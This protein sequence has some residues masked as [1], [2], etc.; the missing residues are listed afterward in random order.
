[1]QNKLNT[2]RQHKLLT[3]VLILFSCV[4]SHQLQYLVECSVTT[5]DI[6]HPHCMRSTSCHQLLVHRRSMFERQAQ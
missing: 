2:D 5:R 6:A 3:S 1:V 4:A